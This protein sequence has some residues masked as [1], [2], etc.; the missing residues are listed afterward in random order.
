MEWIWSPVRITNFCGLAQIEVVLNSLQALNMRMSDPSSHKRADRS[1]FYL[2]GGRHQIL[3]NG[4]RGSLSSAH[5]EFA[6]QVNPHAL[7]LDV[8]PASKTTRSGKNPP[9][10]STLKNRYTPMQ[11]ASRE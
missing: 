9:C 4:L 2:C 10:I 3:R 1:S 8:C 6:H 5:V 7:Y 11:L